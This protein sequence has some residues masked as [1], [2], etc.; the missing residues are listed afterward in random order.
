MCPSTGGSADLP[1][2]SQGK[3]AAIHLKAE[4]HLHAVCTEPRTHSASGLAKNCLPSTTDATG[5]LDNTLSMYRGPINVS[6]RWASGLTPDETHKPYFLIWANLRA[7]R[8]IKINTKG[9]KE[10]T[11]TTTTTTTTSTTTTITTTTTTT[12]TL[13]SLTPPNRSQ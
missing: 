1:R 8:K 12:T 2:V 7:G 3:A 13:Q 6:V 4:Q 5:G 11:T 9:N 10:R